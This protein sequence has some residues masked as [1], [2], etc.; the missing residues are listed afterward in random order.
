MA[1]NRTQLLAILAI[2]VQ[3]AG[4]LGFSEYAELLQTVGTAIISIL[5]LFGLV[6]TEK[7][8]VEAAKLRAAMIKSKLIKE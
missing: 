8:K 5:V 2:L 7:L 4:Q 6:Q 3:V 1:I